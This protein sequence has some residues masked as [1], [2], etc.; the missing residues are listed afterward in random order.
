MTYPFLYWRKTIV[1]S[2]FVLAGAFLIVVQIAG[3]RQ[4]TYAQYF[5]SAVST[6]YATGRACF[7]ANQQ[8]LSALD[9]S[10]IT[11]QYYKHGQWA[12][13]NTATKK[14]EQPTIGSKGGFYWR[15][16]KDA[17][18]DQTVYCMDSFCQYGSMYC[19]NWSATLKA[20]LAMQ[21]EMRCY[22]S[23]DVNQV[24]YGWLDAQGMYKPTDPGAMITLESELVCHA[25]GV[26]GPGDW[27]WIVPPKDV[28][29]QPTG[30]ATGAQTAPTGG[31]RLSSVSDASRTTSSVPLIQLLKQ[32][33]K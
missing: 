8:P 23:A 4:P 16:G 20:A 6:S 11:E 31:D 12:F 29:V 28:P 25:H 19:T 13:F 22:K 14:I 33:K 30:A 15:P 17:P 18:F 1:P 2:I 32:R 21:K 9:L 7:D 26:S 27:G 10:A 3:N 24:W 5:S